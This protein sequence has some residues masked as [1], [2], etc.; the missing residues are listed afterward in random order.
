MAY[1]YE[2]RNDAGITLASETDFRTAQGKLSSFPQ[3][4]TIVKVSVNAGNFTDC[5]EVWSR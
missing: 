4:E 5:C 3:T 2:L 1:V